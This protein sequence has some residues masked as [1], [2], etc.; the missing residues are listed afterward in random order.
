MWRWSA[1]SL[2]PIVDVDVFVW[3]HPVHHA[4]E[5]MPF[6]V[7]E[8]FGTIDVDEGPHVLEGWKPVRF[9]RLLYRP[10]RLVEELVAEFGL[11]VHD[12]VVHVHSRKEQS[13]P[14]PSRKRERHRVLLVVSWGELEHREALIRILRKRRPDLRR[15]AELLREAVEVSDRRYE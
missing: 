3:I 2:R 11:R 14:V 13:I 10:G 12:P 4:P 9:L 5:R 7:D 8:S 15:K 6:A 1:V